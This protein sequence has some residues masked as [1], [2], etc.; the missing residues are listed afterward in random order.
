[1]C[2]CVYIYIYDESHARSTTSVLVF[3]FS[4]SPGSPRKYKL[5][6]TCIIQNTYNTKYSRISRV[7]I[8]PGCTRLYSAVLL[9]VPAV[10]AVLAVLHTQ[11]INPRRVG[12]TV[13]YLAV[14][15]LYLL[16]IHQVHQLFLL[17]LLYIHQVHQC[18]CCTCCTYITVHPTRLGRALVYAVPAVLL[19]QLY[20]CTSCTAVPPELWHPRALLPDQGETSRVLK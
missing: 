1:M 15:L 17:Y 2:D 13:L 7:L 18:F 11:Y 6:Y 3:P 9:F 16:Y 14:L 20:C 10:P 4:A 12:C 19:Y 8:N 5:Y